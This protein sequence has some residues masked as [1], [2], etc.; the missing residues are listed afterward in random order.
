M[1][2]LEKKIMDALNERNGQTDRELTDRIL[3][4]GTPQQSINSECRYQKQK[5][6]LTRKEVNGLIRNYLTGNIIEIN[7]EQVVSSYEP[8]SEDNLKSILKEYLEGDGWNI[9][10]AWGKI[11]GIDIDAHRG[12]ERWI[13][14]VKGSG[15]L[16]PM[17]V[18]YFI[19][20]LGE[21][22][23]RMDDSNAKYS[24][25]LPDM[26]QYRGLWKRLPKLAKERT[27]ISIL[28]VNEDGIIEEVY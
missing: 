18:N 22:L 28:F 12:K 5:G 8:Q 25:A 23:Q 7:I 3:G 15:S 1:G 11:R 24:I 16:Q 27:G 13:I 4:F 19:G 9:N 20:I 26:K 2:K 14:E 6:T 10:V 17:R 21:L